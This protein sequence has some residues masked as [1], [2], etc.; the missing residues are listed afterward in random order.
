MSSAL[1]R[2]DAHTA[3]GD[4]REELLWDNSAHKPRCQLHQLEGS[5]FQEIVIRMDLDLV[6][7]RANWAL[8]SEVRLV[9]PTPQTTAETET[10]TPPFR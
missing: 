5:S 8:L 7:S 9:C 4:R 10:V 2:L 3:L 1:K 6:L